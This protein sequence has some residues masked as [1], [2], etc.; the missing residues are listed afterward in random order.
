MK[1]T[2]HILVAD[3]NPRVC[4]LLSRELTQEGHIVRTACSAEEVRR[5]VF[6][7]QWADV[8]IIDPDLADCSADALVSEIAGRR[9][10]LPVIIHALSEPAAAPGATVPFHFVPKAGDSIH[11]I[12]DC[13]RAVPSAQT[14]G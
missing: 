1:T 4:T 2:L 14:G 3:R 10:A 13:L 12:R 8:L 6:R 9:P 11:P 7:N 5:W